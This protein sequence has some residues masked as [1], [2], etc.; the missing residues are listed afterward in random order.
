[1]QQVVLI[2][3]MFAQV[4]EIGLRAVEYPVHTVRSKGAVGQRL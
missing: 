3:I 1:M 2:S 4:K